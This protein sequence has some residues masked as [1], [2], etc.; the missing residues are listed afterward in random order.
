[1]L[2][3]RPL[4]RFKFEWDSYGCPFFYPVYPLGPVLGGRS[5]GT[6]TAARFFA[7]SWHVNHKRML[8]RLSIIS[9]ISIYRRQGLTTHQWHA[10]FIA[11]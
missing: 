11:H 2:R 7:A 3:D 5:E 6:T 4:L 9:A 1:M 10:I 8:S